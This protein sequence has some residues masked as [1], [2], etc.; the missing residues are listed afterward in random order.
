VVLVVGHKTPKPMVVK[1]F[2]KLNYARARTLGAVLNGFDLRSAGA[3]YANY[4]E[5]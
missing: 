1:A 2:A 4:Y 3:E 5:S